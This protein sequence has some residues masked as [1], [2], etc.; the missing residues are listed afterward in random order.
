MDRDK[1]KDSTSGFPVL[2]AFRGLYNRVATKLNVDPS[3]V[4]RVARGER[5]SVAVLAALEQEISL[6]REHLNHHAN[7]QAPVDGRQNSDGAT[8]GMNASSNDGA[9]QRDGA[10]RRDGNGLKK[11]RR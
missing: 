6:I 5:R 8:A 1:T 2:A 10:A 11:P 9:A 4:S 3:Y 7:G